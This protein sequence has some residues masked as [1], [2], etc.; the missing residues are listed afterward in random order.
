M[1]QTDE[2]NRK[3]VQ[4]TKYQK[5]RQKRKITIWPCSLEGSKRRR[6]EEDFSKISN[7]YLPETV[8]YKSSYELLH[9]WLSINFQGKIIK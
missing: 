3:K 1:H 8:R 6:D 2:Y 5:V 9:G 4:K 7:Y